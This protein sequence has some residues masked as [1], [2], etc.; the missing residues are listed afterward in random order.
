MANGQE[1]QQLEEE[2]EER[3]ALEGPPNRAKPLAPEGPPSPE[4]VVHELQRRKEAEEQNLVPGRGIVREQGTYRGLVKPSMGEVREKSNATCKG[5]R[6][7]FGERK[8]FLQHCRLAHGRTS[9]PA[10]QE[11]RTLESEGTPHP[12][13]LH[14]FR[15]GNWSQLFCKSHSNGA[16][17]KIL[18]WKTPTV[19]RQ[20]GWRTRIWEGGGKERSKNS[21]PPSPHRQKPRK[22][23]GHACKI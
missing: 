15:R 2:Q 12:E 16:G 6:V 3:P 23:V 5:C 1:A 10:R 17:S 7:T 22:P 20:G 9:T 18:H 21:T 4:D 11:K 8:P 19:R 14:P 13:P